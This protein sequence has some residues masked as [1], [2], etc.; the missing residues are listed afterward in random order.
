MNRLKPG[1][2][3][4]RDI[5]VAVTGALPDSVFVHS[6]LRQ[7]DERG[8]LSKKQLEGLFQKAK[9][10]S[11]ISPAK[12]ATLEAIILKKPTRYKSVLPAAEPLFKKDEVVGEMISSI[13]AAYPEHKRVLFLR[14]KYDNN[15]ILTA[16]E[17]GDLQKISKL[18]EGKQR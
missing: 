4:V 15:E 11:S 6:L 9:K 2:D 7:Y 13:L 16:A 3:V 12:L 17:L 8:G 1:V 5:L 14:A 18:V 10:V